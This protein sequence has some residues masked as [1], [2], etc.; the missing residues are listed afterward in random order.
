MA[1]NKYAGWGSPPAVKP[2]KL[3]LA[4]VV[5][6]GFRQ[7]ATR[8]AAVPSETA[9][10]YI[11]VLG[12]ARDALLDRTDATRDTV[13]AQLCEARASDAYETVHDE[14]SKLSADLAD[15]FARQFDD[16]TAHDPQQFSAERRTRL[17]KLIAF[18]QKLAQSV[19]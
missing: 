13:N 6:K 5:E 12:Q 17:A 11:A 10:G 9:F 19:E 2:A 8:P 16:L 1:L 4:T 18:E 14:L 7:V 3:G 15:A